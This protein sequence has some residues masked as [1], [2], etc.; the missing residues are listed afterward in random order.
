[1]KSFAKNSNKYL[2]GIVALLLLV[3]AFQSYLLSQSSSE[4]KRPNGGVQFEEKDLFPLDSSI[5][6]WD[7]FKDFQKMQKRMDSFFG[8]SLSGVDSSFPNMKSFSF[9]GSLSQN[10]DLKEQGDKYIVTLDLPDLDQTKL[11]VSVEGQSLKI[12]GDL[13][14]KNET[15]ND[16]T[17]SQS[18]Q[19]QHFERYLTL[20]GPIKP[21]TLIV[22]Y[23]NKVLKISIE[24]NLV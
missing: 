12:S 23:D 19:S 15:K 2:L 4:T 14:R 5:K 21:E 22:D 16:Q 9:G 6:N 7:P 10:F 17:I 3:V 8:S 1:M 13:E 20:P 18:Y 11:D 24:K